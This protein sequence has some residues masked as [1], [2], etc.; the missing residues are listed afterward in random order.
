MFHPL[1]RLSRLA[2][3]AGAGAAVAYLFDPQNGHDRRAALLDRLGPLTANVP[4]LAGIAGSATEGQTATTASGP[5]PTTAPGGP[6]GPGLEERVANQ[7]R[8][9]VPEPSADHT[10][11]DRVRSQVLGRAQFHPFTILVND[12]DGVIDLR[13][14]IG[15]DQV[16]TELIDAVRSVTGVRDVHDLT[17]RPGEPAPNTV[18]P[19]GTA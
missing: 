9:D 2:V 14:E 13:G 5:V 4:G 10:L 12:V 3:I 8:P 19:R 6:T 17:H 18:R 16:R 15:D 1:R 11:E 7:W